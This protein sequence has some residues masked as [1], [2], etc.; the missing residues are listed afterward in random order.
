LSLLTVGL[1]V[2]DLI[3]LDGPPVMG[4]ADAPILSSTAAATVFIAGAGQ[5]SLRT[6]GGALR[7]LQHARG[8]II[9]AVLTK[10]DAKNAGYGYGYGNYGYGAY[11]YGY[12]QSGQVAGADGG[13]T[14][15]GPKA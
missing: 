15:A 12:G 10:Y 6:V 8:T 7:R 14:L 3:V 5:A 1:D 2:F 13:R 9:G 11:G 4:L